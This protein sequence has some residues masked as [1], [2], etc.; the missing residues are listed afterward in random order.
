[1]RAQIMQL[2][3]ALRISRAEVRRAAPRHAPW[4]ATPRH[5]T[6]RHTIASSCQVQEH[7]N[8]RLPQL[9][10]C[11][12]CNFAKGPSGVNFVSE[13]LNHT[14]IPGK[15]ATTRLAIRPKAA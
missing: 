2:E 13:R 4:R 10:L 5:A 11:M 12:C 14:G 9:K 8:N 3:E 6:P 15:G 1:M 7:K